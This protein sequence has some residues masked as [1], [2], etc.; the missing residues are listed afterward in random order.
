VSLLFAKETWRV[1]EEHISL[2]ETVTND[3]FL[4]ANEIQ[5][6]G[7]YEDDLW[8]AGRTVR[9]TGE[10]KDDLRAV[11]LEVLIVNG[12]VGGDVFAMSGVGNLVVSTNAV[13]HGDAVLRGN[14][15]ITL[16]GTLHGDVYI[17]A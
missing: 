13:V 4:I 7:V 16:N 11:G 10:A 8:A 17:R 15:Q 14:R 5:L 12:P 3:A 2:S 6:N 1:G 9:F